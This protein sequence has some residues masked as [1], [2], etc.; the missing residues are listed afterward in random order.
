[1]NNDQ[2]KSMLNAEELQILEFYSVGPGVQ[3]MAPAVKVLE[4]GSGWGIFTRIV[5]MLNPQVR[6]TT[7]DK[8]DRLPDFDRAVS[9]YR[10]RIE[11]VTG[12]SETE[13]R[14]LPDSSYDVVYVD[15]DHGHRGFVSDFIEAYRICRPGGHII[16]DDVCHA[17][18]WQNDYG[19]AQGLMEMVKGMGVTATVYPVAHGIAVI[20]KP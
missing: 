15:G 5:L 16:C 8:I 3:I 19:V 13:L 2:F 9:G 6:I 10:D 18:N 1:M 11:Q 12:D 20:Q 17:K 7:I 14:R 4:V